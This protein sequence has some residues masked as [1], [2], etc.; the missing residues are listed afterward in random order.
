M[1]A[2]CT[3]RPI[4]LAVVPGT[5]FVLPLQTAVFGNGVSKGQGIEDTQRGDLVIVLCPTGSPSCT[6]LTTQTHPCP[7]SPT[8]G[9]YLVTNYVTEVMPSPASDAGLNGYMRFP[10]YATHWGLVGQ[11][12]AFL[13][14]PTTTCPGQ[15]VISQRSRPYNSAQGQNETIYAQLWTVTVASATAPAGSTNPPEATLGSN[16][17]GTPIAP[18]LSDLVPHPT[19]HLHLTQTGWYATYPA[20]AEIEVSYPTAKVTILGAYQYKHLG[21]KSMLTWK[22]DPVNGKV[23]LSLVDPTRCTQD[24]RVVFSLKP[25]QTPINPA[26]EFTTTPAQQRLYDL[27]G[28]LLTPNPYIV[29]AGAYSSDPACGS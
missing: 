8:E 7:G 10:A 24:I 28:V 26:T 27:N 14:V 6:G 21:L 15:Y 1:L 4:P 19:A 22:D 29:A 11:D 16:P 9:I 20:A 3:S 2:A 17:P 18:D 13:D 5:T 25:S 12:L 23:K